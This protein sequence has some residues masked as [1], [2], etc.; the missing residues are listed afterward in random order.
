MRH[1]PDHAQDPRTQ[2]AGEDDRRKPDRGLRQN[3]ILI[4]RAVFAARPFCIELYQKICCL[5]YNLV[6]Y[7][8]NFYRKYYNMFENVKHISI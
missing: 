3:Q 8:D 1:R 7:V 4:G 5:S 6:L 2:A